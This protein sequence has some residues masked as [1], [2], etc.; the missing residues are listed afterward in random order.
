M[1]ATIDNLLRASASRYGGRVAITYGER[2][3]RYREFDAAVDRLADQLAPEVAPGQRAAI[4]APNVPALAAAMFAIW[5]RGGVAVPLSARYREYELRRIL[6]DAEPVCVVAVES[7]RGYSFG[8][9]LQSLLPELPSVQRCLFVDAWGEPVGA[10]TAPD[11]AAPAPEPLDPAIGVILYT[12][13]TTGAPKGALVQ[14]ARELGG[15]AAANEVLAAAPQDTA[16]FVIPLSHAFGLTCF[17][18]TIAAGGRAVLVESTFSPEPMMRTIAEQGATL[19]HGSPSLFTGFL[20]YAAAKPPTLRGGFVAGAPCP[21]DVL[22][23]LDERGLPIMNL[24]GMTE[25][26]NA[27]CCRPDDPPELRHTTVGRPLPG[28]EFRLV[29]A[30]EVQVRG[31]AV[32][33]GY[34]RQPEQTAAAFDGEWFRTGDLG[35]IDERGYLTINGRMK[36]LIQVGGFNVFPAEVEGLL[37]THPDVERAAVVGVPHPTMGEAVHAF[38]VARAGAALTPAALVQF[39]RPRIAGYKLP[40][41]IHLLPDLPAL[42]SGKPDRR[43]LA[44]Q[45]R[46]EAR[47]G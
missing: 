8:G 9:L 28:Y 40:Y 38:V 2:D 46:E 10:L 16:I 32:T 6:G 17:N 34:Y 44:A 11:T 37:L 18:A 42:A 20:K 31:A 36:E 25:I 30:G 39:A 23:G 12:S 41:A 15:S 1:T 14:H 24:F 5:R 3:W 19:L 4:I 45:V 33:P 29:G 22:A 7:Y 27:C 47:G 35:R 26:G 21:P 43:A 13:G